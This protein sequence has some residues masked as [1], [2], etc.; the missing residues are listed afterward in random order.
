[1]LILYHTAVQYLIFAIP[2]IALGY[3]KTAAVVGLVTIK[4]S[5]HERM[6]TWSVSLIVAAFIMEGYW[7]ATTPIG[8]PRDGQ[9]VFMWHDNLWLIRHLFFLVLPVL[10]HNLPRA[11]PTM[12]PA[13]LLTAARTQ[14]EQVQPQLVN[15]RF[16]YAAAQRQPALRAA[17]AEWWERQRVEGEW[18][19]GVE[20]AL[21]RV[22]HSA[23]EQRAPGV[24]AEQGELA[25][26][27]G[28]SIHPHPALYPSSAL[29]AAAAR[30]PVP[31]SA[32]SSDGLGADDAEGGLGMTKGC[33]GATA[34]TGP[35]A[36]P[37]VFR[38]TARR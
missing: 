21:A 33:G 2:R 15:A 1:M 26:R 8:I 29:P 38:S 19:R 13:I 31:R 10:I 34:R 28:T 35:W 7:I 4:G 30:P 14:L 27:Q 32:R 22:E 6:R 11:P 5:G 36:D 23:R 25:S 20:V 17:S 16:V 37:V 3:V 9:N 18:E 12:D 24:R